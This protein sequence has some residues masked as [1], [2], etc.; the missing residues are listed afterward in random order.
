[1]CLLHEFTQFSEL[2]KY[3]YNLITFC[4]AILTS[5]NQNVSEKLNI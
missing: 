1:M 5:K 3:K 2:E 4:F